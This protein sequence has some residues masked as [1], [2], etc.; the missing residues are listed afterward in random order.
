MEGY[1]V[2]A[3]ILVA[4]VAFLGFGSNM[5]TCSA[6]NNITSNSYNTTITNFI[7]SSCGVTLYPQLCYTSLSSYASSIQTSHM[8]LAYTAL[9]VSMKSARSTSAM[10]SNMSQRQDLMPREAAAVKDCVEEIGD[11]ID[12]LKQSLRQ[13]QEL[14]GSNVDFQMSNIK[15]WVSAALSNDDT[16]V[17]GIDSNDI[18]AEV[19]NTIKKRILRVAKLTSNA[20]ALINNL[21][22]TELQ[23]P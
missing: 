3:C 21:S 5:K 12:E 14:G 2:R 7:R 19:K 8:K 1:T 16:C 22:Y 10:I 15:T 17:D 9:N 6:A 18:N 13:M 23:S 4:L 11:S 20:L